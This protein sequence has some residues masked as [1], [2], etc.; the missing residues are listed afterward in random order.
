VIAQQMPAAMA[1]IEARANEIGAPLYRQGVEW[2]VHRRDDGGLSYRGAVDLDLP[3]PGLLGAHQYGNAG[4]ALACLDRLSGADFSPAALG[5]GLG[6]VEWPARLQ[7][8]D[9][10]ALAQMMPAGTELWLDGGHNA[11]GGAVLGDVARTWNDKPL[12]LVFGMLKTHDARAFLAGLTPYATRLEAIAI[13]GEEN[14]ATAA[15]T[16]AAARDAGIP[17]TPHPS[18]TD[19]L[20]AAMAPGVRVLIC[21]S[22]YLAG[23]VLAENDRRP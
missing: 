10:G 6:E 9:H 14:S 18:I 12:H 3:A 4:T 23:R 1:V 20:A 19:A 17:A 21:G 5:R 7:R 8:L 22:L 2:N 15:D 13:P 16:A 11:G